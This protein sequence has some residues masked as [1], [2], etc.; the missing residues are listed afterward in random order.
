MKLLYSL[1]LTQLSP[2]LA[3][4]VNHNLRNPL[5]HGLPR[6]EVWHYISIYQQDLAHNEIILALAKLDFNC[7]KTCIERKLA[8]CA[9]KLFNHKLIQLLSW[10]PIVLP[11]T[12]IVSLSFRWW[13]ELDVP[14]NLPFARD[15]IVECC[16]WILGVYFE[17]QYSQQEK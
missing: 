11:I 7:Y 12:T 3:A 6:F 10:F 17:P 4:Q 8:T 13:K 14:T 16:L 2:S 9:S 1:P 15:R 5:Y